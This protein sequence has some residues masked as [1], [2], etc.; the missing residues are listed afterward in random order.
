MTLPRCVDERGRKRQQVGFGQSVPWGV[1]C[2]LRTSCRAGGKVDERH[3]GCKE[4][5]RP[6]GGGKFG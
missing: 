3:F 5:A 4:K 2:Q 6:G 1:E